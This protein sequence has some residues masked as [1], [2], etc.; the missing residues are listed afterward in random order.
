MTF[1]TKYI[2]P[3][4]WELTR[5]PEN[6]VPPGL[7]PT[8]QAAVRALLSRPEHGEEAPADVRLLSIA[9]KGTWADLAVEA[10]NCRYTSATR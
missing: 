8:D 4:G 10:S 6:G 2:G 7:D 3:G 9:L 1:G 5:Y